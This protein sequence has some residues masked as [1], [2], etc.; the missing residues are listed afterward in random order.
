ME[1]QIIKQGFRLMLIGL[2]PLLLHAC[3]YDSVQELYPNL[4]DCDTTNVTYSGDVWPVISSNCT[5]C[6]SGAAPSGNILLSNYEEIVIQAENGNLTGAI[7][8]APGYSPMPKGGNQLPPC[9]IT[10]IQVWINQGTPNN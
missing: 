5:A 10:H 2:V 8:H 4:V 7:T 3:Y 1:N 6:H 9:D